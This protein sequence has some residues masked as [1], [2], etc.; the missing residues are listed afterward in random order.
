M[1][2]GPSTLNTTARP[3]RAV[4]I[5]RD[6]VINRMHFHAEYGTVDS[7]ANPDQF[8]LMPGVGKAIAE[9]NRLGLL[10]IVVSNQPGI[11]K[12]KFTPILLE[13]MESKMLDGIESAGGKLDAIY[14]CLHHPEAS[15]G[16]YRVRCECRKPEPGLLIKAADQWAIDLSSSYMIGDGVTDILAGRR[17]GATTLFVS[18][19]KCY[20]CDSLVE[21]KVWPDYIVSD[22]REA[23]TVIEKLEAGDKDSLRQ[24]I[25]KCSDL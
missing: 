2:G 1:P 9:L 5:D 13:A 3:R 20:N 4:F 22:L 14:N 7:P 10:V 12:G 16:E 15:L 23:V 6:G 11:A 19:R 25:L 24:F 17:A 18:S 8:D 21:H